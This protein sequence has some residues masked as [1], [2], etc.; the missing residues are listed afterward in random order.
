VNEIELVEVSDEEQ[1][2]WDD[3]VLH[4]TTLK[5]EDPVPVFTIEPATIV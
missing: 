2:A 3:G 1:P 4:Q 5:V